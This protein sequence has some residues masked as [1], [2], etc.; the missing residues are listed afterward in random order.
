VDLDSAAIWLSIQSEESFKNAR[1]IGLCEDVL[2]AA[3]K[4]AWKFILKYRAEQGVLPSPGIVSENSGQAIG[5]VEEGVTIRYVVD[6]L[7]DR[8]EFRALKYG[9]GKSCESLEKGEQR[10]SREEVHKLSDH[11]RNSSI[12]KVRAYSLAEVVP[13]VKDLYE[14]TKKGEI[15]VPF[16]WQT[17]TEVTM[18]MWPKTLTGFVARPSVGKTFS[19]INIADHAHFECNKRVLIVSPEM[20]RVELAER[21]V[22]LRGKI[23]FTDLVA[24]TLGKFV[25]PHF[26]KTVT[27]LQE[28]ALNYFILDDEDRLGATYIEEAVDA[29]KPDLL[30]IDSIYMLKVSQGKIKGGPGSKGGRYDRILDTIDWLRSFNRRCDIPFVAVSQLA[31]GGEVKKKAKHSLKRGYGTGGLENALA[32]TDT[33]FWDF[34]N[35][36]AMYQDEDM[37]QDKQMLYVPLKARRRA[38]ISSIVT[39]WD[40]DEMD[41]SEIGTQVE[42]SG[43][44]S[45]DSYGDVVF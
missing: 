22:A 36:F 4:V 5:F 24:A 40:L 10:E 33:F 31:R 9:L 20:T 16:P 37:K 13:G 23:N 3:G 30:G 11:L 35:L 42:S 14:R 15:G 41:F 44:F 18:G 32:M 28:T 7:Y 12:R 45:D 25:E 6:K 17:M 19:L 1:D 43:G 2:L 39:R 38:K 21:Q 26:Y 27:N 8:A 29:V 34:H